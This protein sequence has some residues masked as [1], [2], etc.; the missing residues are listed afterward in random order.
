MSPAGDQQGPVLVRAVGAQSRARRIAGHQRF[1]RER[2]KSAA[3]EAVLAI[4]FEKVLGWI[5]E[6]ASNPAPPCCL[7]F[8]EALI[9]NTLT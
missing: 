4:A 3:V 6:P 9:K 5:K 8:A 2:P 7:S 1:H